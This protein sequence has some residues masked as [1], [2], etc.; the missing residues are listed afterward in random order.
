MPPFMTNAFGTTQNGNLE[1]RERHTR[2]SGPIDGQSE[3]PLSGLG[4][5]ATCLLNGVYLEVRAP[6]NGSAAL[7]KTS[8]RAEFNN[9]SL[10]IWRWTG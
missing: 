9:C 4:R 7:A 2:S 3:G 5:L 8:K 6:N 10:C 1:R